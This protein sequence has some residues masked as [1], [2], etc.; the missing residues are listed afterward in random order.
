MSIVCSGSVFMLAT[1]KPRVSCMNFVANMP[2]A[3]FH[4][5]CN[6]SLLHSFPYDVEGGLLPIV[7]GI[8]GR[9]SGWSP[10]MVVVVVGQPRT[11]LM[12]VW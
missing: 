11:P 6:I 9:C 7:G 5:K 1:R 4:L 12:L 8:V 3:R 2:R 10:Q